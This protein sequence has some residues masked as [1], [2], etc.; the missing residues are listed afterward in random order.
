MEKDAY[1]LEDLIKR[2]ES[3]KEGSSAYVNY[4]KALLCLAQE[5][6]QLKEIRDITMEF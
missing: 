2:L 3:I 4:S 5:I 6:Q 1:T